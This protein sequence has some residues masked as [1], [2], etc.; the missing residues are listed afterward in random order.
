MYGYL[1]ERNKSKTW[2]L[3]KSLDEGPNC[4][5]LVLGDFN[6]ILEIREK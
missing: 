3:L 4:A 1:E 5:W 6:E 2:E